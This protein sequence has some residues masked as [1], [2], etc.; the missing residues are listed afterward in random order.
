MQRKT[1]LYGNGLNLLTQ[2]VPKWDDLLTQIDNTWHTSMALQ[3]IAPPNTVQYDQLELTSS[4]SSPQLMANLCNAIHGPW[5]NQVYEHL[6]SV[7]N[8]NFLTTN[9]D[10]TLESYLRHTPSG[11][12]ETLYNLYAYYSI[13]SQENSLYDSGNIWHIHGDINRTQSIIL[14]YDHYCKQIIKIRDYI[15][16]SYTKILSQGFRRKYD[17]N[18]K[19]QSWVDLFF[20]SDIFIVGLG[21]GFA[22]L[23][24]WWILDLW[25]R[26]KKVGIVS[27][28]IIYLDAICGTLSY[29]KRPFIRVLQDFGIKYCQMSDS[30]YIGA[31]EKC[32]D[33]IYSK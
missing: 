25:A 32:L 14:G 1:I 12:R 27:N 2:G 21:L 15:P 18:W 17:E 33:Y 9:Y 10:L 23:D 3:C 7:P 30:T 5:N 8:V 6:S 13:N 19:G 20:N 11:K 24:L 22:E 26:C 31:Y 16:K 29:C 28:E 4:I